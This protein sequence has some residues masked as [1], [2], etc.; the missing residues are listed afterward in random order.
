MGCGCF[1]MAMG[2]WLKKAVPS[3]HFHATACLRLTHS[4]AVLAKALAS[5]RQVVQNPTYGIQCAIGLIFVSLHIL[6]PYLHHS[7]MSRMRRSDVDLPPHKHAT[8]LHAK[9]N[10]INALVDIK[11]SQRK[12][13]QSTRQVQSNECY[14]ATPARRRATRQIQSFRHAWT[15][16]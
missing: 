15:P 10:P 6:A 14:T 2:C 5:S 13:R 11:E 12:H 1:W 4:H 16:P 9:E 8:G 3:Q 7:L